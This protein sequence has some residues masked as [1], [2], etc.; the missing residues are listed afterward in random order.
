[1]LSGCDGLFCCVYVVVVG[2]EASLCICVC[3]SDFSVATLRIPPSLFYGSWQCVM[4]NFVPDKV[5]QAGKLP[6]L[7]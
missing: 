6:P 1:M 5:R 3:F 4:V 7:T 2:R